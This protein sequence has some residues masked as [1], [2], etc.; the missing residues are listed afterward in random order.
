VWRGDSAR[1]R[2]TSVEQTRQRG[3]CCAAAPAET[4]GC[5]DTHSRCLSPS[6]SLCTIATSCS[7]FQFH[8]ITRWLKTRS[9]CPLDDEEWDFV[10]Y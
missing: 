1:I 7:Y 2:I 8:C 3:C 6:L 4:L 9:T 10:M 5:F